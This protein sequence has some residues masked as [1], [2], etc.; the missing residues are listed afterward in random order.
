MTFL[1]AIMFIAFS[2]NAQTTDKIISI[3]TSDVDAGNLPLNYFYSSSCSQFIYLKDEI[4]KSGKIKKIVFTFSSSGG[5]ANNLQNETAGT[6][7]WAR[8]TTKN[9][10]VYDAAKGGN[11]IEPENSEPWTMVANATTAVVDGTKKEVTF[12]FSPTFDYNKTKNLEFRFLNNSS[13]TTSGQPKFKA[14]ST[15]DGANIRA[16]YF[17]VDGRNASFE[18]LKALDKRAGKL[19]V[20]KIVME[21]TSKTTGN[22]GTSTSGNA[23]DFSYCVG[24]KVELDAKTT[25][26]D[27]NTTYEWTEVG[28]TDV[29]ATTN[30]LD[31]GNATT[32]LNNKEYQLKV[33]NGGTCIATNKVKIVV[34]EKPEFTEVNA[35]DASDCGEVTPVFIVKGTA[36]ATVKYTVDAET[37]VKTATIGSNGE[38][39]ITLDKITTGSKK[40]TITEVVKGCTADLSGKTITATVEVLNKPTVKIVQKK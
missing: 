6:T 31:L 11:V 10:I 34:N 4:K 25:N 9:N 7:I 38:V 16:V 36:G 14:F 27:N 32:A 21:E 19:P 33:S 18:E 20:I 40:I 23:T 22:T 37:E 29:K 17:A 39:E 3:G 26:T 5:G 13:A 28:K 2:V 1:M 30:V 35:K 8:H 15:G 12:T 24:E